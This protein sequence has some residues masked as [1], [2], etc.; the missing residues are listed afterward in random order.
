[1]QVVSDSI[2]ER[3]V[4]GVNCVHLF[5]LDDYGSHSIDDLVFVLRQPQVGDFTRVQEVVD[6][7]N[8]GL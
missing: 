1:M 2:D 6:V 8:E 7:F 4:D 3:L 5:H